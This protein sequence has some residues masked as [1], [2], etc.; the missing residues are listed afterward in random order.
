LQELENHIKTNMNKISPKII[1]IYKLAAAS[2]RILIG[3]LILQFGCNLHNLIRSVL[4]KELIENP[5]DL[6]YSFL[7]GH[8]NQPS[9]FLTCILAL[10]L[11]IFSI[12]EIIFA[13]NLLYQKKSGAIGLFIITLLWIPIEILFISKFLLAPKAIS[14]TLDIIILIALF[15]IMTHPKFYFK[16]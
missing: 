2:I 7:L 15:K 10:S 8:I 1:S 4:R 3:I 11:I 14:I 13:I 12:L 5:N 6:T 9:I 16:N